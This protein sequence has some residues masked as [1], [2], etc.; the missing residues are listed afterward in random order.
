MNKPTV[1]Q[2]H[3]ALLDILK[4]FM[5]VC[6]KNNL[7]WFL[8]SGSLLGAIREGKL[9]DWDDDID[10][11]MPR[12][13]YN[14]FLSCAKDFQK[15]Y[16]LQAPH[17]DF[18]CDYMIRVLNTNISCYSK[19]D[20]QIPGMHCLYI[21]VF[22]LDA[23]PD[24]SKTIDLEADFLKFV[25]TFY[26]MRF[27]SYTEYNMFLE[28]SSNRRMFVFVNEAMTKISYVNRNSK[29][30]AH[31]ACFSARKYRHVKFTREAY[32]KAITWKLNGLD[33]FVPIGYEEVLK[34]WYGNDWR[35]PRNDNSGH[36]FLEEKLYDFEHGNE[37]YNNMTKE[38]FLSLFDK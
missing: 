10:V 24:D 23:Y 3:E 19:Y 9:I 26:T 38:Q 1:Q 25:K 37:Y 15:P 8:D 30:V 6:E 5:R 16:M 31:V 20:Y 11:I 4:E 7:R 12:E 33:V 13:D 32:S 27:Q 17:T 22:P 21:D 28:P 34:A 36:S 29:Y 2:I 18:Y 14:I 35:T